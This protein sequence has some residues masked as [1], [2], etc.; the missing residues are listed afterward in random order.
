MTKQSINDEHI[1]VAAYYIWEKEGRPNGVDFDHWI[2][3][4][5]LAA[6]QSKKSDLAG[7]KTTSSSK[8]KTRK[9]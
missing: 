6:E 8:L 5:N 9:K 3:A 7:R 4:Q 1:R 2:R